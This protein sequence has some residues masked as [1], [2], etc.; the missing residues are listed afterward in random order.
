MMTWVVLA[1]VVLAVL[2]AVGQIVRERRKGRPLSC[3]S[4]RTCPFKGSCHQDPPVFLAKPDRPSPAP[5]DPSPG[6]TPS[7]DG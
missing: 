7:R 4:C 1:A 5:E 3:G 6:R 2:L